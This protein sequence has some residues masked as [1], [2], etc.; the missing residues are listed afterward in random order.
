MFVEY[1]AG[2]REGCSRKCDPG[3]EPG[4]CRLLTACTVTMTSELRIGCQFE[5]QLTA[6][7]T[8]AVQT[9]SAWALR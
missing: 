5:A 1:P 7:T 8:T 2:E 4:A 3:D 6:E 9:T